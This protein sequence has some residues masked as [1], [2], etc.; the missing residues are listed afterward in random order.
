LSDV[1]VKFIVE[2]KILGGLAIGVC[3]LYYE[4]Y[5]W[6]WLSRGKEE[7]AMNQEMLDDELS[8]M[9]EDVG[10]ATALSS[11]TFKMP[12]KGL[13]VRRPVMVSPER[14]IDEV[15]SMMR[16]KRIGCVL[17]TEGDS[18]TGI[19][20][21]RDVLLK[22]AGKGGDGS[23][24]IREVMTPHPQAFQSG[25]S[26]AFVLNAMHVGGYRHIPVVNDQGMPVAVISMR[27]IVGFI[28]E[29]FPQDVLNLPPAPIR[30][31]DQREGA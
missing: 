21:E 17:V 12:I 22:V 5:A 8:Q 30:T 6:C 3:L 31:T 24:K 11:D 25:D 28:L 19:F 1:V 18:L 9:Y 7:I 27:D 2:K 23:L 13:R 29:H 16:T 14:S 10:S 4:M 20:T 26:V 15:V